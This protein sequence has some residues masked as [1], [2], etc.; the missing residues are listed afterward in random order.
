MGGGNYSSMARAQAG[1]TQS[2]ASAPAQE[3]F[4]SSGIN[5]GMNPVLVAKRESRDSEEHPTSIPIIIGLD[6]TGSM[7]RIPQALIG[8]GLPHMMD[9]IQAAGVEHAQ[10]MFAAVGDAKSDSAPLQVGEFETS[11][12]LMDHWLQKVY[13]EGNGGGNG[14]ESYSLVWHFAGCYTDTDS[15]EKRQ[16]KGILITIG[17]EC[18]H[19]DFTLEGIFVNSEGDYPVSSLDALHSAQEYYHVYHINVSDSP[20]W[21]QRVDP[22]TY[23]SALL[24]DNAI[25]C[26]STAIPEVI[27]EIVSSVYGMT[28]GETDASDE[29][30]VSQD[31][32]SLV[33]N[34]TTEML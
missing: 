20:G 22:R 12:K 11:D 30:D 6:V 26:H 28:P 1:T 8:E 33:G 3:N 5:E 17:D 31:N 9:K 25:H 10:V 7:G 2:F 4:K 29:P 18:C 16:Q 19:E 24:G 23:W 34:Q 13:L 15:W 27:A 21:G 32:P 14:G